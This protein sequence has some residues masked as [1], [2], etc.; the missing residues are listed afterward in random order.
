MADPHI[1][2]NAHQICLPAAY[3]LSRTIASSTLTPHKGSGP[4]YFATHAVIRNVYNT[5]TRLFNL[6]WQFMNAQLTSLFRVRRSLPFLWTSELT[7][8]CKSTTKT[9]L[10]QPLS[11]LQQAPNDRTRSASNM[12]CCACAHW[13]PGVL[14]QHGNYPK[15][16]FSEVGLDD[17]FAHCGVTIQKSAQ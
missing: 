13:Q 3:S 5:K 12:R 16:I 1:T 10:K 7:L 17:V 15:A 2:G 11:R 9:G 14:S 4:S 6:Y 8:M